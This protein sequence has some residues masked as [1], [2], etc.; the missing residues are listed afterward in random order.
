MLTMS[1]Q[2]AL[3]RQSWPDFEIRGQSGWFVSW[4]GR[5]R[6]F[7]Q[8]YLVRI[9]FCLGCDLVSGEISPV[10][11]RVTV[12]EPLLTRRAEDP[13]EPI[14]HHYPNRHSPEYPVLCLYDPDERLWSFGD[15]IAETTVP[16]AL[17]WLACYEGW[18]ATGEWTGGGRHPTEEEYQEWIETKSRRGARQARF[19]AAAFDRLGRRIGTFASFPLMA[20]ESGGSSRPLSWRDWS[21]VTSVDDLWRSISTSWPEPPPAESSPSAW[22]PA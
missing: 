19:N 1:R 22:L 10:R 18:Q 3:M 15:A 8:S 5:L 16:W 20:A 4:E 7:H 9:F 13:D 6:P 14:P 11:P 2:V 17:N 12:A 21:N